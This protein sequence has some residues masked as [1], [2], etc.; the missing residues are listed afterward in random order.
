MAKYKTVY[1]MRDTG[2]IY[3]LMVGVQSLKQQQL[4][5]SIKESWHEVQD[6]NMFPHSRHGGPLSGPQYPVLLDMFFP[7]YFPQ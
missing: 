4:T 6:N 2:K 7:K 1:K 3:T 5:K